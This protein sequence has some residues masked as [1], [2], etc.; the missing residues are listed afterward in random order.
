MTCLYF[1]CL[2]PSHSLSPS[3]SLSPLLI[4]ILLQIKLP[5]LCATG[6]VVRP[7]PVEPHEPGRG[8]VFVRV[9]PGPAEQVHGLLQDPARIPAGREAAGYTQEV[10]W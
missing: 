9:L 1:V 6:P 7:G 8:E 5:L 4:A 3:L 2:L 10:A